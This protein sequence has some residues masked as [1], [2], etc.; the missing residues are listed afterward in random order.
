MLFSSVSAEEARELREAS[1]YPGTAMLATLS[2]RRD[3]D[4][5]WILERKLDGIR[6]IATRVNGRV[7][8]LSRGAKPLDA[9]FC[10]SALYTSAGDFAVADWSR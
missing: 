2:D 7:R 9:A 1:A 3:F 4:A 6:A 5:D 10:C 8:L